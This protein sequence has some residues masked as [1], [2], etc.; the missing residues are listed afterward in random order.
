MK[1]KFTVIFIC[2]I[3]ASL[4]FI[5]YGFVIPNSD[6]SQKTINKNEFYLNPKEI[7]YPQINRFQKFKN[8]LKYFVSSFYYWNPTLINKEKVNYHFILSEND[9]VFFDSI[10]K[11]A[12]KIGKF[13]DYL[14]TNRNVKLIHNDSI[15][16]VKVKIHGSAVTPHYLNRPSVKFTVLDEVNKDFTLISGYEMTYR[17]IF[18]NNLGTNNNLI[19]EGPGKIVSFR[20]NGNLLDGL[21]IPRLDSAQI[22]KK[23]NK[24]L[25]LKYK[26]FPNLYQHSSDF[27]N[28]YFNNENKIKIQSDLYEIKLNDLKVFLN[29]NYYFSDSE[30]QYLGNFYSLLY[31]LNNVHMIT[32]DNE[33]LMVFEDG[34]YP[35][36]RNENYLS[37]YNPGRR[38]N[39]DEH[40]FSNY[41]DLYRKNIESFTKHR[42]ALIDSNI[43]YSRNLNFWKLINQKEEIIDSFDS[44]YHEYEIIHR[45]YNK[46]YL[47][48]R[49]NHRIM[50]KSLI[51]NFK[52]IKNYLKLNSAI[53]NHYKDSLEIVIDGYVNFEL[54]DGINSLGSFESRDFYIDENEIK[55]KIKINKINYTGNIYDLIITNKVTKD[56]LNTINFSSISKTK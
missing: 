11:I 26:N 49:S 7:F 6:E 4:Y 33:T 54:F 51:N 43:R 29:N 41:E 8:N 22:S 17:N 23:Y 47:N 19:T 1:N 9:R 42:F 24:N 52:T 34:I 21:L 2:I 13:Y 25:F 55:S 38:N 35:L 14:K 12:F 37:T 10:N 18:F 50:K 28:I 44:I 53:I 48:I 39:F 27:D 36:F 15:F 45:K 46:D 16:N 20:F 5:G 30:K 32:G 56:T 31:L 3:L 40:I